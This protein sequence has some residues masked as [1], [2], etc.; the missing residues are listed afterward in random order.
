MV[1]G[2]TS[3]GALRLNFTLVDAIYDAIAAAGMRPYVELD[4]M[5]TALANGSTT[6]LH[7][8]ANVT[9]PRNLTQ[10]RLV[11][12]WAGQV[13]HTRIVLYSMCEAYV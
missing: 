11:R 13:V 6:Y 4:F 8:K 2:V 10:W 9:P 3:G 7:Y 12:R 1:A 5:P